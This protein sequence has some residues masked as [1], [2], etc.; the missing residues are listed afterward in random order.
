MLSNSSESGNPWLASDFNTNTTVFRLNLMFA[1]D[2]ERL[3]LL[4]LEN[5]FLFLVLKELKTG[6]V[7]NY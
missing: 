4:P 6:M 5:T 2:L 1:A 7:V 3:P